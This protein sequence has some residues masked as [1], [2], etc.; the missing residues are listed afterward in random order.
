MWPSGYFGAAF[1]GDSYWG[2]TPI[3]G[4]AAPYYMAAV[5]LVADD[6]ADAVNAVEVLGTGGNDA[7]N[8][9]EVL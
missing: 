2:G 7:I 6:T 5:V 9:M 3:G 1:D 8:A 4:L